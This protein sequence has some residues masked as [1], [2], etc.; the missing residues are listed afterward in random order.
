MWRAGHSDIHGRRLLNEAEIAA[1]ASEQGFEIIRSEALPFE[2]QVA[3]FSEASV[4]AGPHGAGFV[5]M[6]FAPRGARVIEMIGPCFNRNQLPASR[7]YVN[8]ASILGQDFVRIVGRSDENDPIFMDHEPHETYTVDPN[9]F[10]R[11]I[12][13]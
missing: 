7:C 1:I 11:A 8:I 4:I 3:L 12:R 13:I 6:V 9:E 5:N 2:T 10:R